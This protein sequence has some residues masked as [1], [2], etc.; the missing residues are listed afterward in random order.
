MNQNPSPI[1]S[2]II[3]LSI[4]ISFAV[5]PKV[6]CSIPPFFALFVGIVSIGIRDKIFYYLKMIALAI[7]LLSIVTLSSLFA[8]GD[9][10]HLFDDA[11]RSLGLITSVITSIVYLSASMTANDSIII[12]DMLHIPRQITYIL[13]TV[14]ESLIIA[15][16][17][18]NRIIKLLH[19]KGLQC[20]TLKSKLS[21]YIR[22]ITP[23]FSVLVHDIRIHARSLYYRTFF[24]RPV[25]RDKIKYKLNVAQFLWLFLSFIIMVLGIMSRILWNSRHHL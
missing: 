10:Y 11:L 12:S 17:T 1:S 20:N 8:S 23:L 5:A 4:F 19:L 6:L 7:I 13:V 18:G 22:I 21:S 16:M 9:H 2:L 3:C 14:F 15:K 24:E 25:Y